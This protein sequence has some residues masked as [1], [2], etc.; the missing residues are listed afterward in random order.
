MR[1]LSNIDLLIFD[2]DGT[3]L[4][5]DT[6]NFKTIKKVLS[7]L[8]IPFSFNKKDF[9]SYI[10]KSSECF[11]KNILPDNRKLQWEV[12]RNNA[13][14]EYYLFLLKYG[15]LYPCIKNTLMTLRNRKYKLVLYSNCSIEYLNTVFSIFKIDKYFDYIECTQENNLTKSQIIKKILNKFS[16]QNAVVIGD[17]LIDI[18]A[19]KQ[20]NISS[21]C[22]LYGF[23]ENETKEADI[24]INKFTELLDIFDRRNIIFEKIIEE[25]IKYKSNNKA[26]VI[27]INGIDNSGKTIFAKS[28]ERYLNLRDYKTQLILLDDFHNLKEKRYS[29]K[30]E[31]DNYYNK[32]FNFKM[33][34]E[35]ILKSVKENKNFKIKLNLLNLYTDKFDVERVYSIDKNTIVILEGVFLFKKELLQYIDYKVFLEVPFEESKKRAR[36]RDIK[37]YGKEIIK[38]YDLKYLPAQAKYLE[39]LQPIEIADMVI[40]NLN[41]DYPL[42]KK[43][44]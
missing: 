2:I 38:K 34:I 7:D 15:K 14:K 36:N 43:F 22:V 11:Y 18:E 26:F 41:W 25:I 23:G 5:S 33:I 13:R 32:S 39:E 1:D 28:L 10:G 8:N 44:R 17:R 40:D 9:I 31:I 42:I 4:K 29:G 3:L 12:V 27:G 20:N 16:T 35:K 24:K 37:I 30:D 19:A 21:I 6:A